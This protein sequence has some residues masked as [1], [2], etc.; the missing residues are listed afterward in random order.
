MK[1]RGSYSR[2]TTTSTTS[3]ATSPQKKSNSASSASSSS[4]SV[5]SQPDTHVTV[6]L[7]G[8]S[9]VAEYDEDDTDIYHS[10]GVQ[11]HHH[12]HQHSKQQQQHR[13]GSSNLFN[14]GLGLSSSSNEPPTSPPTSSLYATNSPIMSDETTST[15]TANNNNNNTTTTRTSRCYSA[16]TRTIRRSANPVYNQEFRF[17]VA[18]DTLLQ[19]E[20]LLFH[21]WDLGSGSSSIIQEERFKPSTSDG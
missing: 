16:R 21:V 18:D 3:S 8:H 11:Q 20:P 6:T 10:R 13:D 14:F 19:D 2:D 4:S 17:E 7:G 15:T 9:A 12:N 1:C 5:L